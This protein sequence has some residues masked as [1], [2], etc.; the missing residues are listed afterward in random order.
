MTT[1][2]DRLLIDQRQDYRPL[3]GCTSKDSCMSTIHLTIGL[4]G[5]LLI[6]GWVVWR[7]RRRR[8]EASIWLTRPLRAGDRC[9]AP[10][11]HLIGRHEPGIDYHLRLPDGSLSPVV[12]VDSRADDPQ[13]AQQALAA[14]KA[15]AERLRTAG[16]VVRD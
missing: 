3:I 4:V 1:R 6:L 12:F 7:A 5:T 11:G 16:H 13:M 8:T 10:G 15:E 2:P 9:M 14:R